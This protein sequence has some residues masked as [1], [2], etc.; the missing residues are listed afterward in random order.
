MR[1]R[2]IAA[3]IDPQ[4]QAAVGGI[5]GGSPESGGLGEKVVAASDRRTFGER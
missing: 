5:V 3:Q 2:V 1:V 4:D